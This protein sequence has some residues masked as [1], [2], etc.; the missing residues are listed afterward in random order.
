M[1]K[2]YKWLNEVVDVGETGKNF[3]RILLSCFD[4][5]DMNY[6][7]NKGKGR[8]FDIM[9][10]GDNWIDLLVNKSINIKVSKGKWLFGSS[11]MGNFIPWNNTINKKEKE[12]LERKIRKFIKTNKINEIYF[13]RPKNTEIEKKIT[14]AKKEKNLKKLNDLFENKNFHFDKLGNKFKVEITIRENGKIGYISIKKNDNLFMHS[15]F[16][17]KMGGTKKYVGF[18]T[19]P[20]S[21]KKLKNRKI[22]K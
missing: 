22:K 19:T 11:E 21:I 5:L 3:E 16:P 8:F 1:S 15:E 9:P 4:L 10:I 18:R 20:S 6:I 13:L 2:F 12:K 14:A 17:R 7:K